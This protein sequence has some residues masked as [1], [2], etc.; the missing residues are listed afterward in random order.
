[1]L[2]CALAVIPFADANVATALLLLLLVVGGLAS[3]V[4]LV[5]ALVGLVKFRQY[6]RDQYLLGGYFCS[7]Q[8]VGAAGSVY[9]GLLAR[10]RVRKLHNI[11]ALRVL[12][13]FSQLVSSEIQS[14]HKVGGVYYKCWF[15][16]TA[17]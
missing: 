6:P 3:S 2:L 12:L 7:G 1:M 8:P 11:K 10:F 15:E 13:V 4:A 9:G 14:S 5:C 17:M 16:R